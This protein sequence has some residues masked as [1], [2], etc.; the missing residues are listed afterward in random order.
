LRNACAATDRLLREAMANHP[1]RIDRL[2]AAFAA[3]T[4]ASRLV[5]RLACSGEDDPEEARMLLSGVFVKGD[6][7]RKIFGGP[8]RLRPSALVAL[9]MLRGTHPRARQVIAYDVLLLALAKTLAR[10][11]KARAL[12]AER[13]Q[14]IEKQVAY[15]QDVTHPSVIA[16]LAD[17]YQAAISPLSPR[18]IVRGKAEYLRDAK[19]RERQRALL[20]AGLR[21]AD[22][23][24]ASGGGRWT[25]LLRKRALLRA[26]ER[27][28]EEGSDAKG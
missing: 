7:A 14:R 16:A 2:A 17:A 20:L 27:L 18:I 3:M 21:A 1:Q 24:R 9:R 25:L 28:A 6:D 8:Q 13:L 11:A 5:D 26:L 22:A 10:D 15:F 19:I 12:L 4:M 23:W